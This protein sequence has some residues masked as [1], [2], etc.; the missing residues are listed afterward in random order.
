MNENLYPWRNW[1]N[2]EKLSLYAGFGLV[3][4]LIVFTL[5]GW[6][7]GLDNVMS[8][9]IISELKEKVI[10]TPP[11]FFDT[12]SFSAS[13]PL[14]Y[15]VESF[16]PSLIK[17]NIWAYYLLLASILVGISWILSG[18]SRLKGFWF[19][20]GAIVLGFLMVFFRTESLYLQS[21][22]TSFLI[23]FALSGGLYYCT[24]IYAHKL[25]IFSTSLIWFLFW[26][27]LIVIVHFTALINAPLVSLA[28]FGLLGAFGITVIFLFF[29]SH[30]IYAGL[31]A[32]VSQNAKNGKSSIPEFVVVSLVF[33]INAVLIYLENAK[34][35][36]SSIFIFSPIFVYILSLVLGFYGFRKLVHEREWFSFQGVGAWLYLGMAII[37]TAVLGLAYAT[38]NTSLFELLEDYIS[39]SILAMGICF[40]VHVLINFRITIQQGLPFYK[41]LYKPALSRL[42]LARI[43]AVFVMFFLF[44]LK[45]KHSFY[46]LKSGLNNAIADFYLAEGDIKSAEVYFK[47]AVQYD[48]YNE[49]S[50]LS[51]ASIAASVGDE[52]ASIYYYQQAEKNATQAYSY[53][54]KSL[55]YE[56]EKMFFDAVFTLKEG[57]EKY[58]EDAHLYTNL[59]RLQ[60]KSNVQDSV[61][62]NLN[63]ALDYCKSCEVESSNFLAFWLENGKTEK[64]AEMRDLIKEKEGFSYKANA[65]AIQRIL[66]ENLKFDNFSV[67][68]DSSLDM[69][70]AAFLLNS[71]SYSLTENNSSIQVKDLANFQ[72]AKANENLHEPLAWAIANQNYYREDKLEGIKQLQFMAE[73]PSNLA[74]LYA[75]NLGIWFM[76]E[77]AFGASLQ[78]LDKAGDASSVG[79]LSASDI[80]ETINQQLHSQAETFGKDLRLNTYKEI[81]NKAP[82]NPYLIIKVSDFLSKNQKSLEAYNVVFYALNYLNDSPDL[83]KVYLK[84]ALDLSMFEYAED[85]LIQLKAKVSEKEFNEYDNLIQNIK[86]KQTDFN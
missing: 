49:K 13:S 83:L 33:L 10:Q 66:G 21:S 60:A 64:L 72:N 19:L 85:A 8:W 37:S 50:N 57:L 58:P 29:I 78:H 82:L 5:L 76:R 31:L 67:Q 40:F 2:K 65:S 54:G 73:S 61:L 71:M 23:L 1:S 68:K 26:S 62:L 48:L 47:E 27:I 77:G 43:A 69:S 9:D 18:L 45:N 84:R 51:L 80:K 55:A 6:N 20:V 11:L 12:Y 39:I 32:L 53:I 56:R 16:S 34:R 63:L 14:W 4:G 75:Q 46:Q 15:V 52:I 35:I 74:S 42:L 36:D 22:Q 24:N 86:N 81:L 25:T 7:K 70:R 30:E 59:A 3:F 38:A 17:V 41:V 79:I 28:A 44:S